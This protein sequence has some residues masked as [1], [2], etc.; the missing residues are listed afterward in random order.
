MAEHDRIRWRCR[1]GLLELDIVLDR[2]LQ[3]ELDGLSASDLDAFKRLL[4]LSDN[5][6][7][8]LVTGRMAAAEGPEAGLIERLRSV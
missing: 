5:D 7:W 8:D 2:F 3:R 6:L 4:E 1:R